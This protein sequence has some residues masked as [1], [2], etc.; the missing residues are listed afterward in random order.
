MTKT[1]PEQNKALVLEAF[2]ALFNSVTTK[3]LPTSGQRAT[4]STAPI[5]SRAATGYSTSSAALQILSA[6]NTSS[7][8]RKAT[9]SLS[10]AAS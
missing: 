1:T 6:T 5:S 4:S 9:T 3:P 7:S 2:D 10:M 8:W